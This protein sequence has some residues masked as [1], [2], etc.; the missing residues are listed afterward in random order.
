MIDQAHIADQANKQQLIED[1]ISLDRRH[2]E[3]L[4][5]ITKPDRQPRAKGPIV[6]P[7]VC[8]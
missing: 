4:V 1:T 8:N 6:S 7:V 2:K 3:L 5:V